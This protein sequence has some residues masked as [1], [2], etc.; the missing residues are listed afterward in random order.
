ML[1]ASSTWTT[2]SPEL[3]REKVIQS[4]PGS[5]PSGGLFAR[6]ASGHFATG[7]LSR[8]AVNHHLS[9][10]QRR[11]FAHPRKSDVSRFQN[12]SLGWKTLTVVFHNQ[13]ERFFRALQ[14]KFDARSVSVRRGIRNQLSRD[15]VETCLNSIGKPVRLAVDMDGK[16]R[17]QSAGHLRSHFSESFGKQLIFKRRQAQEADR[18]ARLLHRP[19]SL[20]HGARETRAAIVRSTV[21]IP[22]GGIQLKENSRKSLKKTIVHLASHAQTFL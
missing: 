19:L 5:R 4:P 14:T 18:M 13:T 21:E 6:Y 1:T 8:P 15:D 10:N 11:P 3:F 9:S 17:G 7:A 12:D 20:L 2:P 22:R 16:M